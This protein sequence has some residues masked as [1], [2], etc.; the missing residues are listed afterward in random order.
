M[1]HAAN[2]STQYRDA[3]LDHDVLDGLVPWVEYLALSMYKTHQI[4]QILCDAV[5]AL[6]GLCVGDPP[7]S[8]NKVKTPLPVLG[9]LIMD[10]GGSEIYACVFHA[11]GSL[12]TGPTDRVSGYLG[13]KQQHA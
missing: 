6:H 11:L 3:L 13:Y 2:L 5:E 8:L 9:T 12:S 1:K 7:P 4:P 10:V